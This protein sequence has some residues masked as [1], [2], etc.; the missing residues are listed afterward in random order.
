MMIIIM[1]IMIAMALPAVDDG[2]L[3]RGYLAAMSAIRKHPEM[4]PQRGF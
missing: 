4:T 1:P 3:P 2:P